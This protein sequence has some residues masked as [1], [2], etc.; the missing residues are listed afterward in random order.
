MLTK[1]EIGSLVR[2][3]M[4]EET[5]RQALSELPPS[6]LNKDLL[7]DFIECI[8]ETCAFNPG[9]QIDCFDCSGTGGS[10]LP[11]FNTSTVA[12]F[13]L[14][15]GGVKVAKFGNKASSGGGGSF[16]LLAQ[17]GIQPYLDFEK[18]L[19]LL[20][21][22]G[23]VF[24]FAPQYYPGLAQLAPIRKSLKT[25]TVFNAIGPLLHPYAPAKRVMG[26][27]CPQ[28][29][30]LVSNYLAHAHGS[31]DA[32]VVRS[33]SGLD[34]FDPADHSH[35]VRIMNTGMERKTVPPSVESGV[36]PTTAQENFACFQ[37]LLQGN[38]STYITKLVCLNAG[39]GFA[40]W[41][42]ADSIESGAEYAAELI[43]GGAVREKFEELRR[44]YA[45]IAC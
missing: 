4:P 34:E 32:V 13:V 30:E 17:S 44:A 27:A 36:Q 10:G 28:V 14:A 7:G 24:L 29:Q 8:K 16:D 37:E 40:V 11:H 23:L 5:I 45:T 20:D 9:S 22:V 6:A 42:V 12:A 18:A 1:K 31:L 26:T 19:E 43:D 38:A 21:R 41:G 15:A 39:V 33:Q 3:E 25:P 35:Y 2:C